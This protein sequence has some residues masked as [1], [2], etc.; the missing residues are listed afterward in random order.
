[1]HVTMKREDMSLEE[2]KDGGKGESK[3]G[4]KGENM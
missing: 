2:S 4:G 3:F 1:M